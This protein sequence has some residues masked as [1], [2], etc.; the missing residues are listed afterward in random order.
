MECVDHL[1]KEEIR[2]AV[3]QARRYMINEE[4]E[5][6]NRET[7]DLMLKQIQMKV[8]AENALELLP[9]YF[10]LAEANI[11]MGGSRLKKAEEFLI[12]AKWNLLKSKN[13]NK[14]DK[15][16]IG[17]E[18]LLDAN[19]ITRFEAMLNRM[20][21]KLF[22]ANGNPKAIDE[23]A[24]GIYRDSEEFGPEHIELSSSYFNMGQLFYQKDEPDKAKAF[25]LKICDIWKKYVLNPENTE[26]DENTALLI[27]EAYKHLHEVNAF[28]ERNSDENST[29]TADCTFAL[30][31]VSYR[32][33]KRDEALDLMER[34]YMIYQTKL[35]EYAKKTKDVED[36]IKFIQENQGNQ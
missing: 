23:L 21:G 11:G 10:I 1:Q 36:A 22:M 8:F 29:S 33:G 17:D 26:E 35:G 31:L 9:A 16:R 13:D 30:A 28:L 2:R 12:A 18:S 34:S 25:Y 7:Y 24:L 15:S 5:R 27:D 19:E 32:C 20:F 14:E 6:A 3:L 4:F